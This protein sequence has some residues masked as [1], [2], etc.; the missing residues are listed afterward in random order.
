MNSNYHNYLMKKKENKKQLNSRNWRIDFKW[1]K[2][3]E[4][5]Y[6]KKLADKL[7]TQQHGIITW[8]FVTCSDLR[9]NQRK[10]D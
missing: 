10:N 2:T 4:G 5:L 3:R 9:H 7:D 8:Q 6:G 1:I